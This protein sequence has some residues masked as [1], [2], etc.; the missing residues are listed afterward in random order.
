MDRIEVVDENGVVLETVNRL[1]SQSPTN[2]TSSSSSSSASSARKRK[3]PFTN[4][5]PPFPNPYHH[6]HQHAYDQEFNYDE[7]KDMDRDQEHQ[8]QQPPLQPSMPS[9]D[10]APISNDSM[11]NAGPTVDS[12]PLEPSLSTLNPFYG[13]RPIGQTRP[14]TLTSNTTSYDSDTE[15]RDRR[16]SKRWMKRM[17]LMKRSNDDDDDGHGHDHDSDDDDDGDGDGSDDEYDP[18]HMY[19]EEEQAWQDKQQRQIEA[20]RMKCN[21]DVS[22]IQKKREIYWMLRDVKKKWCFL[23][24]YTRSTRAKQR[25]RDLSQ[26]EDYWMKSIKI[27]SIQH[28]AQ[29]IHKRFNTDFRW[30]L[31]PRSIDPYTG[32]TKPPHWWNLRTIATHFLK[33]DVKEYTHTAISLKSSLKLLELCDKNIQQRDIATGKT[34]IDHRLYQQRKQLI[35]E[36][37]ILEGRLK[38]MSDSSDQQHSMNTAIQTAVA[39][40][41]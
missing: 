37:R 20:Y 6:H 14:N 40:H 26:L 35:D 41:N 3:K 2:S 36:V 29:A 28:I 33:H 21:Y 32:Q 17:K 13:L 7:E 9:Q 38:Q 34:F 16:V 39:K 22:V 10:I 27:M 23:C 4:I 31:R 18:L 8:R 11:F 1:Q 12:I 5:L 25:F 30:H 24:E 15:D 19:E